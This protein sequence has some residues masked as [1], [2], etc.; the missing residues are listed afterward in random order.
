M[1]FSFYLYNFDSETKW[2]GNGDKDQQ[3]RQ[4]GDEMST[5]TGTFVA[6]WNKGC[7]WVKLHKAVGKVLKL[8]DMY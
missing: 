3:N 4:E 6:S 5:Q 2:K 8:L 7:V 1:I